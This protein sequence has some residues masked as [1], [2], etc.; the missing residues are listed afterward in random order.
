MRISEFSVGFGTSAAVEAQEIG[1]NFISFWNDDFT[2]VC[3]DLYEK[4]VSGSG[5]SY[6]LAQSNKMHIVKNWILMLE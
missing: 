5:K 2:E 3:D 6:R 1:H 4:I